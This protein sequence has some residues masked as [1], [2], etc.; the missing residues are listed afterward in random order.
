MSSY[1]KLG[2]LLKEAIDKNEF[3]KERRKNE[4][5][6]IPQNFYVYKDEFTVLGLEP[7]DDFE[8]IK[9]NYHK[10]LKK[11]H[12]DNVPKLNLVQKTAAQK[13]QQ[14]VEAFA[15]IKKNLFS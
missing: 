1:D 13:T 15:K 2:D 8:L 4:K 6:I 7:T 10:L 14:V 5:K 11:Y 3:P 12:P 9:E